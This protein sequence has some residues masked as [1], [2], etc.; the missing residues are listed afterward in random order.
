MKTFTKHILLLALMLFGVAGAAWADRA[1]QKFTGPVD[2]Y[3]LMD[4]DTLA[5]GFS[6]TYGHGQQEIIR[7]V[8]GRYSIDGTPQAYP[9]GADLTGDHELQSLI[10][11]AS[12]ILLPATTL[13]EKCYMS[14]F[15]NC[16]ALTTVPSDLLP[17]T[18]LAEGPRCS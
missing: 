3:D 8:A 13:A 9:G 10:F 6:L 2:I 15:T 17:A 18:T 14:M 5:P 12:N 1:P 7:F 16:T 11:T 4:G